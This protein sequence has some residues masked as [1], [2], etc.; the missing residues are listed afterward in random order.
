MTYHR[1]GRTVATPAPTV[2]PAVGQNRRPSLSGDVS[3]KIML[4]QSV[5]VS[6]ALVGV[7]AAAAA[8]T[9]ENDASTLHGDKL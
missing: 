3:S 4:K 6:P 5:A 2:P 8:A 9:V 7:S 1:D